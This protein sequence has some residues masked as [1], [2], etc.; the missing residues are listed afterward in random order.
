M[1]YVKLAPGFDTLVDAD[2]TV[3]KLA[4]GFLFTEGPIWH[5][6][7]H[8][9]LF[10]DMPGDVRRR[11]DA[12]GGVREVLR[13]ANKCNGMSYDAA[14]NLLVCEHATS[15]LVRETPEGGREILA[16]HFEGEELNSPND[17]CVRSD[18][19][20]YFSDPWY[21]R[22]SGFGVERPRVLGWQGVFRLAPGG[23]LQLLVPRGEFAMP[24]GLCFSPDESLL[25]VNDTERALIRAYDV[26][27]D[28]SLR[29][30]RRFAEGLASEQEP[31]RPDGMKCD[32]Q[33][34]VWCTGPGGVWIYAPSGELAGRVAVP[35]VVGNLHW[36]GADFRTLLLAASTSL[37]VLRTRVKPH[38]E[39]FMR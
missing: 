18:G 13:P 30:G 14:L 25:Y 9:L 33:G 22:M 4:D 16:S 12:D 24:N 36:G 5:P 31:G 15:C 26:A 10:S 35:E 29:N 8:Y 34:N 6:I 28:G 2:E 37:Y 20:I 17:V 19:S 23:D 11:W 3:Q 32:E 39:P 27:A 7:Q 21:G 1:S 38:T